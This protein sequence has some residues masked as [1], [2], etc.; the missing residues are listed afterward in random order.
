MNDAQGKKYTA[1]ETASHLSLIQDHLAD[2][3]AGQDTVGFCLEC[4]GKHFSSLRG[5]A[6][7]GQ[8]FFPED[9]TWW[10][11]LREWV[12]RSMDAFQGLAGKRAGLAHGRADVAHQ[13]RHHDWPDNS[14]WD[15]PD[16][17]E[18]AQGEDEAETV[19]EVLA[20]SRRW[21]KE[22]QG[23]Y[24]GRLGQCS[25]SGK[26]SCDRGK[27]QQCSCV[28]GSEACCRRGAA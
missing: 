2:Y 27:K 4:L 5:L 25:S 9:A 11:G 20:A 24:F 19:K 17:A 8:S 18:A 22:L 7:E 21:R 26:G 16:E 23:M 1:R 28:T 15:E 12:D 13:A 6:G 14:M 10:F 3:K